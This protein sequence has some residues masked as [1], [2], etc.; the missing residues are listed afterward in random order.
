[1]AVLLIALFLSSLSSHAALSSLG[2][3]TNFAVLVY[4]TASTPQQVSMS[5][6]QSGVFG[7]FGLGPYSVQNFSDGFITGT[8][9]VDPTANNS[10]NNNVK[11]SLLGT[12]PPPSLAYNLSS[13]VT[14]A[15]QASAAFSALPTTMTLGNV[16]TALTIN[17]NGGV[18]VISIASLEYT[19]A[20]DILTLNGNA[21]EYFIFNVTAGGIVKMTHNLSTMIA[22]GGLSADHIVWNILGTGQDV[23][24][25]G[26]PT[27][28][29]T[30]LALDRKVQLDPGDLFGEVITGEGL[31]ITS[32]A[33]IHQLAFDPT[34][35]PEP[36]AMSLFGLG[37]SGLVILRY[38]RT[39]RRRRR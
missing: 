9:Y 21:N 13:A 12:S 27:V 30:I 16:Q 18:N 36:A 7:N 32:G 33:R 37:V 3:A 2:Q 22:N 39:V 34:S 25:T 38:P 26:N 15:Q 10:H 35:I 1:M 6:P 11:S 5:N 29:G 23:A 19:D 4:G 8:L 20:S 24:F 17:G 28:L 31:S 14:D